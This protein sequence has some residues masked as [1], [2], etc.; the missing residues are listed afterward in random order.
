MKEVHFYAYCESILGFHHRYCCRI[1]TNFCPADRNEDPTKEHRETKSKTFGHEQ[2]IESNCFRPDGRLNLRDEKLDFRLDC[3]QKSW[4]RESSK[5]EG[6]VLWTFSVV[7]L[8]VDEEEQRRFS[9]LNR[10]HRMTIWWISYSVVNNVR[11]SQMESRKQSNECL[12]AHH[13]ISYLSHFSPLFFYRWEHSSTDMR[14]TNGVSFFASS[15]LFVRTS[16][17]WLLSDT[18]HRVSI[19]TENSTTFFPNL[20]QRNYLIGLD[21]SKFNSRIS[22]RIRE[23]IR[24]LWLLSQLDVHFI[25][26]SKPISISQTEKG[27]FSFFC[28]LSSSVDLFFES[29]ILSLVSFSLSASFKL[30][31]KRVL[32]V[33]RLE[34]LVRF[35]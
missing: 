26:R 23:S 24:I 34:F 11:K 31:Q 12:F 30:T 21:V 15:C 10:K 6:K 1:G 5:A 19:S 17:D 4:K 2:N 9:S 22:E 27:E 14:T 35:G 7:K 25:E 16:I 3:S 33:Q 29:N 8:N 32:I 13:Q 20:P 18:F 28:F